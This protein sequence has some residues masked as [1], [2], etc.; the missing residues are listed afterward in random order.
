VIYYIV[1]L[2]NMFEGFFVQFLLAFEEFLR[3]T[4]L[5]LSRL[6]FCLFFLSNQYHGWFPYTL[7]YF[8][9]ILITSQVNIKF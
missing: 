2:K 4:Q 8:C 6:Y 1:G 3:T 5:E 9:N 7:T